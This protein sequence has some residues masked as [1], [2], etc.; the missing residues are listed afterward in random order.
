MKRL[1]IT[2]LIL[3][4]LVLVEGYFM[5]NRYLPALII[6]IGYVGFL[7]SF[8]FR[9]KNKIFDQSLTWVWKKH[10]NTLNR[11]R[12]LNITLSIVV[13]LLARALYIKESPRPDACVLVYKGEKKNILK[14]EDVE[15]IDLSDT[16]N[17]RI[18]NT[19]STGTAFTYVEK[20]SVWE[21]RYKGSRY[22]IEV[23][24]S[25]MFAFNIDAT[26]YDG[27]ETANSS[28]DPTGPGPEPILA[29]RKIPENTFLHNIQQQR[30]T[31][32]HDYT[33]YVLNGISNANSFVERNG[34][35]INYN[36]V[37]KIA[38]CVAYRT[39]SCANPAPLTRRS[40]VR[41]DLAFDSPSN[42]GYTNS[43]YDRGNLV[44]REDMACISAEAIDDSYL[45]SSVA[46]Q[47]PGMDIR[48]WNSIEKLTRRYMDDTLYIIAG[49]LFLNKD[50]KGNIICPVI[51]HNSIG[52][53]SHFYRII[54]RRKKEGGIEAIAFIV[55]NT[56][57]AESDLS[58]YLVSVQEVE[59][60]SGLQFFTEL[61]P[62][63]QAFKKTTPSSPW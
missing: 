51:G 1:Q 19:G 37:L 22:S 16:G 44:S 14:N 29:V 30:S 11:L 45:S 20:N 35:L 58:K 49:T 10:F 39:Y 36:D 40:Y 3:I 28:S 12:F 63:Q 21:V 34:F 26:G 43:G 48:T 32:A 7:S 46:P 24:N 52:V 8:L 6:I 15:L 56:N 18:I 2:A 4:G 62:D 42:A 57:N 60:R 61:H 50:E 41:K 38:N 54:A 33:A 9:D 59:D 53:P 23:V 27:T 25:D 31:G 55:P 47:A 13:L 5:L 17:R